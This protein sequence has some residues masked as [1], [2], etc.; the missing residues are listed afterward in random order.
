MQ[1]VSLNK[2][3]CV[4]RWVV[5]YLADSAIHLLNNR[6]LTNAMENSDYWKEVARGLSTEAAR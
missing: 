5:I 3:L 4:I 1:W 2:N 6:G